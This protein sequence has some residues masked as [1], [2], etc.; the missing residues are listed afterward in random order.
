M[1]S[2]LGKKET[3]LFRIVKKKKQINARKE[4]RERIKQLLNGYVTRLQDAIYIFREISK[5]SFLQT[6]KIG[7]NVVGLANIFTVS[8]EIKL[9][10][11]GDLFSSRL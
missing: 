11:A 3:F 8:I 10:E 1:I 4:K 5:L 2:D 7:I 9:T 6:R